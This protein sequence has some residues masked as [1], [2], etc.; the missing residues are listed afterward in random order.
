MIAHYLIDPDGRHNLDFLAEKYLN[1]KCK[2]IS[3]LI[4]PK[5]KNQKNMRDI[6]VKSLILR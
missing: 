2:P 5:G 4:G 6:L 1:Y 3:D